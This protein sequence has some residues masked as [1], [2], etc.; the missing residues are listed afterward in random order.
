MLIRNVVADLK[1]LLLGEASR[2]CLRISLRFIYNDKGGFDCHHVCY[3]G[4]ELTFSELR[5]FHQFEEGKQQKES[6]S[7][8]VSRT[9][10]GLERK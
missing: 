1:C 4:M 2:H 3:H 7:V 8:T 6:E 10:R 9:T 5:R